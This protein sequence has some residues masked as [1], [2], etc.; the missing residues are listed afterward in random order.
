MAKGKQELMTLL[1]KQKK[2][3]E[4]PVIILNLGR[5]F[6]GLT[7]PIQVVE[8]SSDEDDNQDEEDRNIKPEVGM[9]TGRGGGGF[10]HTQTRTRHPNPDPHPPSNLVGTNICSPASIKKRVFPHPPE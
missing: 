7:Q 1:A 2:K 4:K 9:A 6:K 3:T 10:K 5:R 8:V